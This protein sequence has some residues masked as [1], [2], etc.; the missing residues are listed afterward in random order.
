MVTTK[1]LTGIDA[2]A[3]VMTTA[4][5]AVALQVPVSAAVLLLPADIADGVIDGAKKP[6]G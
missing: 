6:D 5:A 1:A 2:E 4:A 3:V